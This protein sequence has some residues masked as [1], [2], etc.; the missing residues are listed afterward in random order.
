[1]VDLEML[2]QREIFSE[3]DSLEKFGAYTETMQK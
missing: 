2:K 3:F 1:M